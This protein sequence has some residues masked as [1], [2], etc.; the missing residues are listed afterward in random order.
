MAEEKRGFI[1]PVGGAEE[2][3]GDVVILKRFAALGVPVIDS[4]IAAVKHAEQLVE[5]RDRFGW[6][7]SKIG[8]YETP[9]ACEIEEWN[10]REEYGADTIAG[11][12]RMSSMG[13]P[14]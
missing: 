11:R 1:V 5:I 14:R 9:P 8:G 4:A 7:T 6:T 2:K 10:L 13:V 3:I 12:W